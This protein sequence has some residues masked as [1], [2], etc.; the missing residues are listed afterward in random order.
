MELTL[1]EETF[2]E[3]TFLSRGEKIAKFW[4]FAFANGPFNYISRELTFAN[5]PLDHFSRELSFA[6]KA[7]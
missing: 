3:E 6:N 2:A 1:K 7:I 5:D 4:K